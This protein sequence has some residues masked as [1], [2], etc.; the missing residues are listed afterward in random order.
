MIDEMVE[1]ISELKKFKNSR[2]NKRKETRI[3]V[4]KDP[5]K[6]LKNLNLIYLLSTNEYLPHI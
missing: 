4:I 6:R 2:K 5:L 3:A 1:L